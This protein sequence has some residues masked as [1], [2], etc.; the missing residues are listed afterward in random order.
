MIPPEE[1]R[2]LSQGPRADEHPTGAGLVRVRF[3]SSA[4]AAVLARSREVLASV[5][6]VPAPRWPA[7]AEWGRL[8]PG[9][10]VEAC[11]PDDA[12]AEQRWLD[13]WRGLEPSE[14]TRVE[15][16]KRWTLD[17]WLSWLEPDEREW[18]WWDAD[19]EVAGGEVV[20]EVPGW[21]APVGALGWLL[22]ASGA[23][24]VS[25]LDA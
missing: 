17:S 6:A 14:R 22:R 18:Y 25:V 7:V 10:F 9:W 23:T 16:E 3:A 5:L 11:A 20:V 24:S 15:R 1:L 21:P 19:T 4:P 12:S 13:W 2:H 8:L